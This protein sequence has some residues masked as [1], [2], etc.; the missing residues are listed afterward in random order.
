MNV[1]NYCQKILFVEAKI[2]NA[3]DFQNKKRI[4]TRWRLFCT[5]SILYT[6]SYRILKL[7]NFEE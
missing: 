3:V 2:Q 4:K 5:K 7:G 1:S 6:T